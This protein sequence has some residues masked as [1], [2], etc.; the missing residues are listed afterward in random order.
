MIRLVSILIAVLVVCVPAAEAAEKRTCRSGSTIYNRDGVRVFEHSR[1][2]GDYWYAC[3]PRS[4][5]PTYL[6]S[7]AGS[8]GGLSVTGRRGDLVLFE[9]AFSGEGGGEDRTLGWF[10]AR[11]SQAR[12]G[13][14][15]GA[16]SN[17]VRDVVVA[18]DGAIGVVTAVVDEEDRGLRI[19]YLA[20][21][22]R[23]RELTDE[24]VLSVAGG[25]YVKGSLAFADGDRSLT[26]RLDSGEA[27]SVPVAG[28]KVTCTSG[29]TVAESA[30]TRVFEVL[31]RRNTDRGFQADVLAACTRGRTTPRELAVAD[32]HDQDHWERRALERAGS[33]TAFLVGDGGVGMIDGVSGEVRF[34]PRAARWVSDIALGATGPLVVAA[35]TIQGG[36]QHA[37]ILRL[38]EEGATAF[39]RPV[40]LAEGGEVVDGALAVGDDGLVTWR[41]KDGATRST[42]LAGVTV[43]DCRSGKTL[44]GKNGL[45]VF[46]VLPAGAADTRLYACPPDAATPV[47]LAGV[48]GAQWT[49]YELEREEGRF[50]LWLSDN[51]TDVRVVSFNGTPGSARA[52]APHK[53]P[54]YWQREDVA[55]AADGRV[56]FAHRYGR[57]WRISVFA[58]AGAGALQRERLIA[59][60]KEGVK[61]GSLG[62]SADGTRVTWRSRTG[63]ERS[64][65]P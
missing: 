63:T 22:P 36:R 19:G 60:P 52:G 17:D 8:Y 2:D 4:R 55:I 38:S 29:T 9:A 6:Y 42:P 1:R 59:R 15:A 61:A 3:G 25:P 51:D 32:V 58:L 10:D 47:E 37:D 50:A 16:V 12:S 35:D 34:E 23:T 54:W 57:D 28:E 7:A 11:T 39:A 44:L 13:E 49:V 40:M 30:G 20:P 5:R 64:A 65:R 56:A 53:R 41:M 31:P 24:L 14:L 62:F 26:W 48:S 33:R 45:R 21:S 46:T 43:V 27:R 18:A